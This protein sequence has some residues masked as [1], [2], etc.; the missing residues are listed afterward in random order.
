MNSHTDRRSSLPTN[1]IHVERRLSG[2]LIVDGDGIVR[3]DN[4]A[5]RH[6]IGT[7]ERTLV[8]R[9]FGL[10]IGEGVAQVIEIV[11]REGVVQSVDMRV[12]RYAGSDFAGAEVWAVTLSPSAIDN[13]AQSRAVDDQLARLDDAMSVTYHELG[14]AVSGISAG[15]T[16]LRE[17]WTELEEADRLERVTRIERAASGMATHL[18]SY[19]D[20]SRIESGF[21]EP[22]PAPHRLLDLVLEHLPDLGAHAAD[23]EVQISANVTVDIDATHC[24]SIVSNFL[25]N[26][27]K[28]GAPPISLRAATVG[29]ET[30]IVVADQGRGV[31]AGQTDRLF[32]RFGTTGEA[33][34]A[35]SSGLGLWIASTMAAAYGGRVWYERNSPTGSRFCVRLPS[36]HRHEKLPS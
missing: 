34:P 10:P 5:A 35:T 14:N 1:L 6:L 19:L 13:A 30:L 16:V 12:A 22:R 15:L 26:A 23:I 11:D 7:D 9:P 20:A 3:Y 28:H 33:N 8:G 32:E 21:F 31:P 25:R 29:P 18:K 27:I 2:V 24:W 17:A 36:A 4:L